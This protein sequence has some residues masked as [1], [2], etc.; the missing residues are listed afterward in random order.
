MNKSASRKNIFAVLAVACIS[1][2]GILTETSLNVT[3]PTLM[4]QFKVSMNTVQWVTTG[5]LLMI[6]VI[7]LSSS[8]Q[9][10]RFT[11]KQIFSF[12]CIAFMVGS[13][14][15]AFA[16]NFPLMLL[17]RL[18]SAFGAG[19]SIPLMF[20]LIVEV[21][22]QAKWGLY[23]GIAGMILAL[24]P[25]LGPSFGGAV[26]YFFGWKWIFLIVTIFAIIVFLIGILLIGKY[27]ETKHEKLDWIGYLILIVAL[28]SV[29]VGF[30]QLGDGFSNW[31]LW[32]LLVIS[33]LAFWGYTKYS[34]KSAKKLL[35]LDV[36]KNKG[37]RFAA[38]AYFLL[39]F[40]NI[41]TSFVLPNY[42]QIVAHQTSLI[43]GLILLPGSIVASLLTP[44]FGS[45]YDRLGAKKLLYT[46]GILFTLGGL[47]FA[48]WGL[49]LSMLM[50]IIFYG[51]FSLGHRMS[52]GNTMAEASKIQPRELQ[53]DGTAVFQ[54]AQQLAGSV[55]T[56]ILAAILAIYQNRGNAS[57]AT[58]TA[59]GSRLTFYFIFGIGVLILI[60][61]WSMFKLEKKTKK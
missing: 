27:H 9:N 60:S 48:I 16:T 25:T 29:V 44:W 23:M 51:I 33:A 26:T 58:L 12:A 39:Q 8:Y 37:F 57:Y 6:A 45:L 11:A 1:F 20:N 17:G 49:N 42:A 31:K 4:K 38:L 53:T 40:G 35:N 52:F 43:G 5:Y 36:F 28:V 10:R 22:P 14:L 19:L 41:G 54:T 2:V 34:Q 3:F 50:I 46:G 21:M 59:Q 18:I 47:L 24:A 61:Y 7:M 56:T 13:L 30:N 32:L 15:S 55:G